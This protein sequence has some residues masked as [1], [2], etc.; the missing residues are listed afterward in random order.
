MEKI[1]LRLEEK[2]P[3]P[4]TLAMDRI[5]TYYGLFC[6]PGEEEKDIKNKI[7]SV[8]ILADFPMK[9]GE[10]IIKKEIITFINVGEIGKMTFTYEEPYELLNAPTL[11]SIFKQI[12]IKIEEMR[13]KIEADLIRA[14]KLNFGKI[15]A[16]KYPWLS[17]L[18]KTIN[19]IIDNLGS[20]IWKNGIEYTNLLQFGGEKQLELLIKS[21]LVNKI[22]TKYGYRIVPTNTFKMLLKE[23]EKDRWEDR[24]IEDLFVGYVIQ[25]QYEELISYYNQNTLK[26]MVRTSIGLYEPSAQIGRCVHLTRDN[27]IRS[28]TKRYNFSKKHIWN[29][30]LN[31]IPQLIDADIVREEKHNGDILYTPNEEIFDAFYKEAQEHM[32]VR[33]IL[34]LD[35]YVR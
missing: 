24:K 17:P 12:R 6:K 7:I 26:S 3:T 22:D 29:I 21:R 1:T 25:E 11:N 16:I 28:I 8:P 30:K 2:K 32:K 4:K 15:E 13:N 19:L 5:L 20:D 18:I 23:S 27:W 33:N 35:E 31:H 9:F 10:D 34:S 14:S